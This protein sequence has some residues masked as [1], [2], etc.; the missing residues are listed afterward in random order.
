M[1]AETAQCRVSLQPSTRSFQHTARAPARV[2]RFFWILANPKT[3]YCLSSGNDKHLLLKTLIW[4]S[5]SGRTCIRIQRTK[6]P[7]QIRRGSACVWFNAPGWEAET[8]PTVSRRVGPPLWWNEVRQE[9]GAICR[10]KSDP[11]KAQQA[12][13]KRVLRESDGNAGHEA[14]TAVAWGV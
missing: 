5:V 1:N 11:G 12:A 13:W 9:A 8:K 3:E 10:W 7:Y 6:A 4:A 14:Y 2:G